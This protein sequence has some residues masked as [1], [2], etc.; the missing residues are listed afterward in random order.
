MAEKMTEK[1]AGKRLKK[2]KINGRMKDRKN[3]NKVDSG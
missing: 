3:C 2:G 1:R